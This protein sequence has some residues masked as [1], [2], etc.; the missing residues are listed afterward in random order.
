MAKALAALMLGLCIALSNFAVA[1]EKKQPDWAQLTPEQ[2]QILAPLASDWNNFDNKRRKKWLLTAKRYPKL[3]PEQQQRL[4]K[5]MH[6]W[7]KLTPEQRR[8]ARE[9]YKKLT[10]QPPE[11][12]EVVKRK[13]RERETAKQPAG[14]GG[15][16][17]PAKPNSDKPTTPTAPSGPP[18]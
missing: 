1:A 14:I 9:N 18:R 3:K 10:K 4:Q 5:Q 7:A 8:I 2:Q 6:V 12:R 16:A 13:W 17:A 15:P 11:K